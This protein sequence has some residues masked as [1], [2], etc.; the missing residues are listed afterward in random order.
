VGG[1]QHGG[2]KLGA[3]LVAV[4]GTFSPGASALGIVLKNQL[5]TL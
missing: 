4:G 2:Q 3:K 1:C 5:T